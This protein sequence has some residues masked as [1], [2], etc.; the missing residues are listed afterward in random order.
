M[1]NTEYEKIITDLIPYGKGRAL[2]L[3][4]GEGFYSEYLKEKGYFTIG[5]DN[6]EEML[7]RVRGKYD[8]LFNLDVQKEL[9][10]RSNSF[11]IILALEVLEHL[12]NPVKTIKEINK[13]L[14]K[15]GKAIISVPNGLL[16]F[17]FFLQ[18]HKHVLKEKIWKKLLL[19]NNFKILSVRHVAII[20]LIRKPIRF[21]RGIVFEVMKK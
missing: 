16:N 13:V 1:K 17:E 18:G 10:F 12:E 9:P 14:K 7:E 4:C 8:E 11:E 3:G 15:N 19:I 6:N 5:V 20:P 2:D 21:P